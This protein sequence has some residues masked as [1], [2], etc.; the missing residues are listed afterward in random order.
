MPEQKSVFD[1]T[2]RIRFRGQYD[3][4]GLI[5][6]L[7]SFYGRAKIVL[8]QPKFKYK[9]DTHGFEVEFDFKG[10]RK[11]NSYINV[12]LFISGH[13]FDVDPKEVVVNGVKKRM[14]GGKMQLEFSAK[15]ELDWGKGFETKEE[16]SELK[17]KALEK[18]QKFL[19]EEYEGIM[20]ED[21][22]ALGKKHMQ[23]MIRK[24]HKETVKF[25]GMEC[26]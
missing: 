3:Y 19:D 10:N 1:K 18:M 12:Y 22:K 5:A 16:D 9:G 20:Y 23:D 25:L 17:K 24:F 26:Y 11:V 4:D 6:L 2:L 14:T 13:G 15:Y 21:N 7:R 8:E